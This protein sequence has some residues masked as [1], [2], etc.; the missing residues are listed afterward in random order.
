ML[1]DLSG[2]LRGNSMKDALRILHYE[3]ESTTQDFEAD[4]RRESWR[5]CWHRFF[6]N[7]DNQTSP[8]HWT[9]AVLVV[10]VAFVLFVAC[11]LHPEK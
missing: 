10:G 8:L 2:G 11:A 9:G 5:E 4:R 6:L 1:Q 7:R 3:L